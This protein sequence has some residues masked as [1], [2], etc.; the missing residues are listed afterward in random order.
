MWAEDVHRRSDT[1][2]KINYLHA[3]SQGMKRSASAKQNVSCVLEIALLEI[4]LAGGEQK[5]VSNRKA[6]Y[7]RRIE[8][9]VCWR[10]AHI[11]GNH[12]S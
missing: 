8:S 4:A 3:E 12:D 11:L 10:M 7:E 5:K 2:K 9:N 1:W 6:R